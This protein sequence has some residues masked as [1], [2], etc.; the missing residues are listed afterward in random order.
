MELSFQNKVALVTGATSGIGEST[1]WLYAEAGAQVFLLG[2]N[3]KK[4]RSIALAMQE[5]GLRAAYFHLDVT[6]EAEV[7]A[8]VENIYKKTGKID[9]LVHSAGFGVRTVFTEL[10]YAEWQRQI[11]I[12]LHGSF[13]IAQA[14][15][16]NMKEKRYGK[17]VF[18]SSG[19]I[20]T[21]TGGG[22]PY[23]AAKAGQLGLMRAMAHELATYNINVNVIGPR[24]IET[25]MFSGVY[26]EEGKRQLI[27][28]IPLKRIAGPE[29]I[30]GLALYLTHD[31]S[32]YITGQFILVDGGRTYSS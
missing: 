22:A 4:G 7:K 16:K 5:K 13:L 31:I 6:D 8:V 12:N 18:I 23:V 14:A 24:N 10:S 26:S 29:E 1:A 30:A 17:I 25:P 2:R 20:I 32:S 19:S 28:K 9:I 27:E 3:E 15:A 21:G 11:E